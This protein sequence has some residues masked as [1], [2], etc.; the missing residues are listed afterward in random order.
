M[1]LPQA[2]F[3]HLYSDSPDPW[4]L[5]VRWYEQRKYA[6]TVASLPRPR[7]R[8]AFE[9]GCSVGVLTE[10][11]AARCDSLLAVDVVDQVV[12]ATARR[13]REFPNVDVMRMSVPGEWPD[14]GFDLIVLSELGYY[15]DATHLGELLERSIETLEPGGTLV[16]V[17]WRHPVEDYPA[18]GDD[19]HRAIRGDGRLVPLA[20]HE[21]PDFLIDVLVKPPFR[22]VAAAEGLVG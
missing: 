18:L 17:H 1:T 20:H 3:E 13:L 11:L 19:V 2:Y 7:Y 5:A 16:A 9:P 14:G 8:R 15:L 21:E 10:Q 4:S 22:S 6:L 12:E